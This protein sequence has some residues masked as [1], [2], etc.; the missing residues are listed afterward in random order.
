M[1]CTCRACEATCPAQAEGDNSG[2]DDEQA[3]D[4]GGVECRACQGVELHAPSSVRPPVPPKPRARTA[5][6]MMSELKLQVAR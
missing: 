3:E 6:E 2:G 4:A 5:A 1:S